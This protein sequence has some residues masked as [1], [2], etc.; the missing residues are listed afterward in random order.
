MTTTLFRPV[1]LHELALIWDSGM[2]QFPPRLS[3]QPIFYPVTNAEYARQ[4]ARDW[5]TRHE[6]S[7][8]AGFVTE[9]RLTADTSLDS[10]LAWWVHRN[11]RNTGFQRKNS[12]HL[13]RQAAVGFAS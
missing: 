2:R 1:G 7:G 5:N 10:L 8:F 9:L 3:H 6:K 11:I 12:A 4:I 13:I